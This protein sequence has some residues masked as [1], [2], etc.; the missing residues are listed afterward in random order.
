M[1]RKIGQGTQI[2]AIV[3]VGILFLQVAYSM[4]DGKRVVY[5]LRD[6][7][8]GSG[9]AQATA[10][11]LPRYNTGNLTSYR[12]INGKIHSLTGGFAK[13]HNDEECAAYDLNNWQCFYPTGGPNNSYYTYGFENGD[14]Y[15]EVGEKDDNA[16][17]YIYVSR[18]RYLY[19]N[20]KWLF[21]DGFFQ[22]A[23]ACPLSFLL[24]K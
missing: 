10:D 4:I 7:Q 21:A 22:G 8:T 5:P 15:S 1:F 14:Y 2:F 17:E 19:V 11:A 23:I 3:L 13:V 24:H 9:A 16:S 6:R 20:C 12:F 18:L